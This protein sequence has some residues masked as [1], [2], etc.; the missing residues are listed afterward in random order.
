MGLHIIGRDRLRA[1]R[2]VLT[3]KGFN[4]AKLVGEQNG[5]AIFPQDLT[6]VLGRGMNGL[7]EIS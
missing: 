5:L 3:D 2:Y 7:S 4:I 6:I 1:V